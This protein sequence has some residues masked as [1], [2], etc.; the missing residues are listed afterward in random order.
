MVEV[1]FY[2]D[3]ADSQLKNAVIISQSAGRWVFC[4]H[5][6]RTT[7]ECPGGHRETEKTF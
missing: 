3:V 7:Y 6:E 4:K 2:D 1:R 5:R